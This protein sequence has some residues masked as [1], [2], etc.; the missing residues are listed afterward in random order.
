MTYA[1]LSLTIPAI[2][3][4]FSDE[5]PSSDWESYFKIAPQFILLVVIAFGLVGLLKHKPIFK[6]IALALDVL[7]LLLT[8]F[9]MLFNT[10]AATYEICDAY[11]D[12]CME[13]DGDAAATDTNI[14]DWQALM[15]MIGLCVMIAAEAL[16]AYLLVKTRDS[17]VAP[18]DAKNAS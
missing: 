4:D 5:F 6:K 11:S 3:E 8:Y 10:R 12:V 17:A 9:L 2:N 18:V 7:A 1:G 14:E 13:D 16:W 15:Y